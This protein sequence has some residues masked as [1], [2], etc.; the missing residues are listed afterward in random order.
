MVEFLTRFR[1]FR[2]IAGFLRRINEFRRNYTFNLTF[3]S[4]PHRVK[5]SP[6]RVKYSPPGVN[7]ACLLRLGAHTLREITSYPMFL[8][9]SKITLQDLTAITLVETNIHIFGFTKRYYCLSNFYICW[10]Y[11]SNLSFNRENKF[12]RNFPELLFSIFSVLLF[13]E[14][15]IGARWYAYLKKTFFTRCG[16]KE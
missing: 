8:F 10:I 1:R 15:L 11:Q 14:L 13:R 4:S 6:L 7:V 16:E 9:S 5:F 3:R 12:G 2:P